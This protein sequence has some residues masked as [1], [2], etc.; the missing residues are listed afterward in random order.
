MT[1]KKRT[2]TSEEMKL[3]GG[4]LKFAALSQRDQALGLALI[5]TKRKIAA[6]KEKLARK[7]K[8]S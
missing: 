2:I 6:M 1:T 3:L 4:P 5:A 8:K 7:T